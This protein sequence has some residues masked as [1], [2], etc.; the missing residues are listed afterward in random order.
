MAKNKSIKLNN[1]REVF[2][3]KITRLRAHDLIT[4]SMDKKQF[5]TENEQEKLQG[6]ADEIRQGLFKQN[7]DILAV[8]KGKIITFTPL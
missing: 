2:T 6:I 7:T 8:R 5:L 3:S 1:A 4:I